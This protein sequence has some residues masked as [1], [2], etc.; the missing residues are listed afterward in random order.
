MTFEEAY[1]NLKE[2]FT[3][4]N[5]VPVGRAAILVEEW[6]AIKEYIERTESERQIKEEKK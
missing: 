1:I 4:G 3:S 6:E 5:D 2:K